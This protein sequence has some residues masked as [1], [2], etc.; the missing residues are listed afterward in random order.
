MFVF[1]NRPVA[2]AAFIVREAYSQVTRTSLIS[3]KCFLPGTPRASVPIVFVTVNYKH[4][5][6]LLIVFAC[7]SSVIGRSVSAI[8]V[9]P[10]YV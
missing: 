6:F 9:F 4:A 1:Y 3:I 8:N 10:K 7:Q 5:G 2:Q